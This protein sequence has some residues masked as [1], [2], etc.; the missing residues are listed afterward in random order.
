MQTVIGRRQIDVFLLLLMLQYV[1]CTESQARSTV[2][3][4]LAPVLNIHL[5]IGSIHLVLLL[6]VPVYALY[7][8]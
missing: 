2:A 5:D 1:A 3:K 7:A 8:S 6:P 4:R